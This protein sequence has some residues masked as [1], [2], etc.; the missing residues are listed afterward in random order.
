MYICTHIYKIHEGT[1]RGIGLR[2]SGG[3]RRD[4]FDIERTTGDLWDSKP[5]RGRLEVF[6]GRKIAENM[7]E[8]D[9]AKKGKERVSDGVERESS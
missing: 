2:T 5:A 3:V 9:E 8:S 7:R 6:G 1:E 4:R